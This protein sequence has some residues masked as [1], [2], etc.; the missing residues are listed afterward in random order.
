MFTA[1]FAHSLK[2][3]ANSP[4]LSSITTGRYSYSRA[5]APCLPGIL[6]LPALP[7]LRKSLVKA[8]LLLCQDT[9]GGYDAQNMVY[10]EWTDDNLPED[11]TVW[12]EYHQSNLFRDYPFHYQISSIFQLK[13]KIFLVILFVFL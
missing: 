6:S 12:S 7:L 4:G 8:E 9:G 3:R 5:F 2:M 10:C 13:H 1:I 11:E